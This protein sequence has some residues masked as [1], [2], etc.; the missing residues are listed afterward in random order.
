MNGGRRWTPFAIGEADYE[1]LVHD[2]VGAYGFERV[3]VPGWVSSREDWH[4]WLMERRWGVPAQPHRRLRE[5]AR[6]LADRLERAQGDPGVPRERLAQLFLAAKRAQDEADHFCDHWVT[7]SHYTK[8]RRAMR[9]LQDARIRAEAA[10][11]SGDEAAARSAAADIARLDERVALG[12]PD[13]QWPAEWEDWPDYP[14]P[15]R[16]A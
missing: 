16:R 10:E 6:E 5:H 7:V 11:L 9:W 14:P 12:V 13:E 2:L 8:S 3:D 15:E 1:E 4:M